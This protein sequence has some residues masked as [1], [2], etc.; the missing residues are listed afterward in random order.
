MSKKFTPLF[1]IDAFYLFKKQLQIAQF[2]DPPYLIFKNFATYVSNENSKG[3]LS[4]NERL[5]IS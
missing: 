2:S 3:H 4:V 5:K 1:R